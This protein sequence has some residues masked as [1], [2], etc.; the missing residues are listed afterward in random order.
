MSRPRLPVTRPSFSST[1]HPDTY[2]I[3]QSFGPGNMGRAID[4][5]IKNLTPEARE[6]LSEMML[7]N[8]LYPKHDYDDRK[9]IHPLLR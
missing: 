2:E 1:A 8:E 6:M 3:L 5:M 9:W 7:M 4:W